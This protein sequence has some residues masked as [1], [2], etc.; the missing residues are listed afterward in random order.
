MRHLIS[1]YRLIGCWTIQR[2]A[3]LHGDRDKSVYNHYQG[4]SAILMMDSCHKWRI[5]FRGQ[6]TSKNC[7]IIHSKGRLQK[8]KWIL[9]NETRA[10]QFS[11]DARLLQDGETRRRILKEELTTTYGKLSCVNA[12][13]GGFRADQPF[14]SGAPKISKRVLCASTATREIAWTNSKR[15]GKPGCGGWEILNS[16]FG[17]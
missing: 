3:L 11:N 1:F 6:N 14:E 17:R 12:A 13:L 4:E 9:S 2:L 10:A 5:W 15:T 7:A 16:L 8:T